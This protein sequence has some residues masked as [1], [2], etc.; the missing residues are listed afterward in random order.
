MTDEKPESG[1]SDGEY[2]QDSI[3]DKLI[4]VIVAIALAGYAAANLGEKMLQPPRN[5]RDLMWFCIL[6]IAALVGLPLS[7]Y[8]L[9]FRTTLIVGKDKLLGMR[10]NEIIGQVPF[11]NIDEISLIEPEGSPSFIGIVLF[12]PTESNTFW[13]LRGKWDY[14]FERKM[15]D[16]EIVIFSGWEIPL[17]EVLRKISLRLDVYREK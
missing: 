17:E 16:H 6:A 4:F 9:I 3:R 5:S 7:S 8:H 10:R 2:I 12:D 13:N 15:Y 11:E 1:N 14:K